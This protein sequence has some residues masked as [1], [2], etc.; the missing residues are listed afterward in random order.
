MSGTRD[1]GSASRMAGVP[2]KREALI[3]G[4]EEIK[5]LAKPPS[6]R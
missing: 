1:A 5:R 6:Q 2:Q 3:R 4:W